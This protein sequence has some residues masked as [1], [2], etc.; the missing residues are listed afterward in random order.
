LPQV[1]TFSAV[2]PS[3]RNNLRD[4]RNA[5][6]RTSSLRSGV[7]DMGE[8][9]PPPGASWRSNCNPAGDIVRASHKREGKHLPPAR[10][11]VHNYPAP[12]IRSLKKWR[13]SLVLPPKTTLWATSCSNALKHVLGEDD[14]GNP[15]WPYGKQPSN[16]APSRITAPTCPVSSVQKRLPQN[17]QRDEPPQWN[18]CHCRLSQHGPSW[19]RLNNCST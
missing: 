13:Y 4:S 8:L 16:R 7:K 14:L 17:Y 10:M 9:G 18:D 1:A 2:C 15:Q 6:P 5:H 12:Q 3:L 11:H 19:R